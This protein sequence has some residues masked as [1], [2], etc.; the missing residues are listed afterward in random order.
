MGHVDYLKD[1][2]DYI[3]IPRIETLKTNEKMCTNFLCLYD[4]VNNTFD[5]INILHYNVDIEK[6]LTLEEAFL[7]IGKELNLGYLQVLNAYEQAIQKQKEVYIRKQKAIKK[8]LEHDNLKI[9][10]AAHSYNIED[11]QIGKPIINYLKK[12]EII[13]IPTN[14]YGSDYKCD[15][16]S[17]S[18]TIYWTYNKQIMTAINKLKDKV[19]GI[20]LLSTFPCGPDSLC[21]ELIIRRVKNIPILYITIDDSDSMTGLITR[22][23]SFIDIIKLKKEGNNEKASN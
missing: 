18:K 8:L 10:I 22:L 19:D 6:G 21:N 13:P 12:E 15:C 17:I 20:I 14:F 16:A 3:L 1:K 9:L 7:T 23:E 11:E 5:D 4:L 2:V